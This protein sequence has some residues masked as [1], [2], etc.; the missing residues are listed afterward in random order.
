[1]KYRVFFCSDLL[2]YVEDFC[3]WCEF[4]FFLVFSSSFLPKSGTPK[5]IDLFL[6]K[7]KP[8]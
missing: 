5:F 4:V 3:I 7:N 6:G 1:M 2:K 8:N